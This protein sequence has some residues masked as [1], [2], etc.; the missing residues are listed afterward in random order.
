MLCGPSGSGVVPG[1][2][3]GWWGRTSETKLEDVH[4]EEARVTEEQRK[5]QSDLHLAIPGEGEN[6]ASPSSG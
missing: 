5:Q 2:V 1:L 6:A 3:S 4:R